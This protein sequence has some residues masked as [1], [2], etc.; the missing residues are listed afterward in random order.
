MIGINLRMNELT[1]A[2]ALGQLK[3]L[4]KILQMLKEKKAKFKDAILAGGIKNMKF[5]KVN[6][7]MRINDIENI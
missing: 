3:K 6:E 7:C 4:N 5:R 1:G 2:F